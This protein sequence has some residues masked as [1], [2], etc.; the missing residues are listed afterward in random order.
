M[1]LKSA[2][3]LVEISLLRRLGLN[4]PMKYLVDVTFNCMF[5]VNVVHFLVMHFILYIFFFLE[6]NQTRS[7]EKEVFSHEIFVGKLN[8][9][10]IL[11]L[12]N[13]EKIVFD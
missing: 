5:S 2:E 4:N 13:T 1:Q 7:N 12:E 6:N 8:C 9:S 10:K 3:F 11:Y